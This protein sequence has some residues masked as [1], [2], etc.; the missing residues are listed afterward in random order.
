MRKGRWRVTTSKPEIER[1]FRVS[2]FPKEILHPEQACWREQGYLA[3]GKEHEATRVRA[4]L[5]YP[6][7]RVLLENSV[8]TPAPSRDLPGWETFLDKKWRDKDDD[9][10]SQVEESER[11]TPWAAW[12][13][14]DKRVYA[15]LTKIRFHF[16]HAGK[17]WEL[18]IFTKPVLLGLV[19]L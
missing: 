2:S 12:L 8:N 9:W 11:I 3:I 19:M 5:A 7:F 13:L 16:E 18:D 14:M 4:E 1:K 17:K 15:R 10:R 6:H